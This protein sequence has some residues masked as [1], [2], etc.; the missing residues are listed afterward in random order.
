MPLRIQ[1]EEGLI[2]QELEATCFS[3]KYYNNN[4]S[5]IYWLPFLCPF[6]IEELKYYMSWGV[7]SQCVFM[8]K[9]ISRIVFW[10][11]KNMQAYFKIQS[12]FTV[13]P[14]YN[15]YMYEYVTICWMCQLPSLGTWTRNLVNSLYKTHLMTFFLVWSLSQISLTSTKNK[16]KK[17]SSNTFFCLMPATAISRSSSCVRTQYRYKKMPF[18]TSQQRQGTVL[19]LHHY[20][21]QNSHHRSDIQQHKYKRLQRKK[22][23]TR[24][25][26]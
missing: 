26:S 16:T 11:G 3:C 5:G 8:R 21:F 22:Q 4:H 14:E 24:N 6:R 19:Q 18:G 25:W 17:A 15:R 2:V 10:L 12:Y 1:T 23:F 13:R 7:F 9:H 20:A